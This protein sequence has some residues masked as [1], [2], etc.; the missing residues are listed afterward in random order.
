[1]ELLVKIQSQG[2]LTERDV[3]NN[4]TGMKVK[5]ASKPFILQHGA[6]TIYAEMIQENARACPYIDTSKLYYADLKLTA[7]KST[8]QNGKVWMKTRVT[9]NRFNEV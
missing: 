1:M 5:F 6:D 4:E 9:I 8:D 3:D 2:A 7:A